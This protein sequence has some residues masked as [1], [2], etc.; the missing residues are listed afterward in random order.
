M[1]TRL[2]VEHCVSEMVS[3]I[4]IIE[5]MIKI[6]EGAKLPKQEDITLKGHSIE[7]RIMAEDSVKFIPSPGK[8]I[9]YVAP[10]VEM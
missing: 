4:D 2:Q 7:C 10:V 1:N 5:W 3:G 9:K 8:V 6:A